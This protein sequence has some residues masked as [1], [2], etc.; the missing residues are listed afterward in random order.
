M[1]DN[2]NSS[3]NV[4]DLDFIY[5]VEERLNL[6]KKD[7]IDQINNEYG[8]ALSDISR[9]KD[10]ISNIHLLI[11]KATEVQDIQK[12]QKLG[13][14]DYPRLSIDILK[15]FDKSNDQ[16]LILT[17]EK[18]ELNMMSLWS[19]FSNIK[20]RFDLKSSFSIRYLA[21]KIILKKIEFI[22]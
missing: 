19:E 8:S 15:S 18:D 22:E 20:D 17:Y 5:Y 4:G 12:Y 16:L 14:I 10:E 13:I 11:G 9:I 3:E 21:D 2:E 1:S 7:I 6:F